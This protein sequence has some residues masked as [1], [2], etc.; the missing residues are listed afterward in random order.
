MQRNVALGQENL[1]IPHLRPVL[2]RPSSSAD[3]PGCTYRQ[4]LNVVQR[5]VEAQLR[6]QRA[7]RSAATATSTALS[8]PEVIVLQSVTDQTHP[9][10]RQIAASVAANLRSRF[11]DLASSCAHVQQSTQHGAIEGQPSPDSSCHVALAKRIVHEA[12]DGNGMVVFANV[13]R[14]LDPLAVA[15]ATCMTE[16]VRLKRLDTGSLGQKIVC[17]IGVQQS[18]RLAVGGKR[19][20]SGQDSSPPGAIA[21]PRLVSGLDPNAQGSVRAR[22]Q[23]L[24]HPRTASVVRVKRDPPPSRAAQPATIPAAAVAVVD[25]AT[26][27]HQARPTV[28]AKRMRLGVSN[29][30][31]DVEA[32]AKALWALRINSNE[33]HRASVSPDTVLSSPRSEEIGREELAEEDVSTDDEEDSQSAVPPMSASVSVENSAET[34][35][36]TPEMAQKKQRR[37]SKWQKADAQPLMRAAVWELRF[38]NSRIVETAQRYG[39]P[40]RTLRRYRDISASGRNGFE[41]VDGKGV[42]FDESGMPGRIPLPPRTVCQYR[43]GFTCDQFEEDV[44][45]GNIEGSGAVRLSTAEFEQLKQQWFLAGWNTCLQALRHLPGA[46]AVSTSTGSSGGG[47]SQVEAR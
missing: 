46:G 12:S 20:G 1:R 2:A 38:G 8:P 39:I 9:I 23:S 36:S 40:L 18:S 35:V 19:R 30:Q 13:P 5:I 15:Q 11:V 29:M 7:D 25:P 41:D 33:N 45:V 21:V 26:A 10:S 28:Q 16:I 6:S 22:L 3:R 34:S 17:L 43:P 4:T 37:K 47:G 24:L 42:Q 31:R 27:A 14:V 44:A 32:G